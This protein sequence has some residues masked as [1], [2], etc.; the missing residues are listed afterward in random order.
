MHKGRMYSGVFIWMTG[1]MEMFC[2][3]LSLVSYNSNTPCWF[4]RCNTT[5]VPWTDFSWRAKWRKHICSNG[6]FLSRVRRPVGFWDWASVC[7][8]TICLD[9][10]HL[11]DHHGIGSCVLANLFWEAI[12]FKGDSNGSRSRNRNLSKTFCSFQGSEWWS[13]KACTSWVLV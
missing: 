13:S 2:N 12:R 1:D 11:L 9:T 7:R 3:T 5:D 4:C 6:D 8:R 10:L